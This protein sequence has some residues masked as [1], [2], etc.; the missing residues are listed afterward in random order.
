[1]CGWVACI[2]GSQGCAVFLVFVGSVGVRGARGMRVCSRRYTRRIHL[3][4][5]TPLYAV[6]AG[7]AHDI[8]NPATGVVN[9]IML[10]KGAPEKLIPR[11]AL[12]ARG[13]DAWS[14]EP[15][16]RDYW[17]AS[18]ASFSKEGLRVLALCQAVLP[19]TQGR[20]HVTDVLDGP[21]RLQIN[22]LVAIVDPP[23]QEAIDAVAECKRA[24]ITTKMI[25]GDH[26]DTART[27]GSWIGITTAEVLTGTMMEQMDDAELEEHV[28]ECNIYARATPEHKLRI[29][30]ALQKHGH[31]CA[32]TGDGVNDA[33]AL[34]QANVGVAMGIT[35]TDVAKEA[36]KM[37]LADDNFATIVRAVKEGRGVYD[38]LVK[39]SRRMGQGMGEAGGGWRG[40]RAGRGDGMPNEQRA[41][42]CSGHNVAGAGEMQAACGRRGVVAAPASTIVATAAATGPLPTALHTIRRNPP[43]CPS[44]PPP[45]V[46]AVRA[47]NELCS[48]VGVGV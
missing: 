18:T 41:I 32:M 45:A 13:D 16:D 1:M 34:K 6:T 48:C 19:P 24:G 31:V 44:T 23:R 17:L 12:Q 37:I 28:E 11:C 40:D 3:P 5:T 10:I 47:A 8:L 20:I 30:R 15:I 26:P 4:A 43:P 25:T 22:A 42:W 39:V 46:A 7:S 33:P 21:P 36:A 38:N 27:I 14:S 35:G 2:G 9:R 29:V